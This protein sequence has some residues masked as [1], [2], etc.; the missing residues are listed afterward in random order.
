MKLSSPNAPPPPE[1]VSTPLGDSRE[2]LFAPSVDAT[3]AARHERYGT[4]METAAIIQGLKVI[5]HA[6]PGWRLLGAD[7]KESLDM[8]ANK[9]GRILRGD[10]SYTDSWHDIAGYAKL[11][12]NRLN[13]KSL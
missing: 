6:A 11:I 5:M 7:Q 13:G 3:L 8:I 12:E 10:S 4:F 2:P 1:F 9:L